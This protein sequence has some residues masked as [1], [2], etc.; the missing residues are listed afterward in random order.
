MDIRQLRRSLWKPHRE[1]ACNRR[2]SHTALISISLL[3]KAQAEI[4]QKKQK[5]SKES[6][7][8]KRANKLDQKSHHK[9]DE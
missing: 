1:V 4:D 7:P 6:T 9:P 2:T 5:K 3:L 8:H